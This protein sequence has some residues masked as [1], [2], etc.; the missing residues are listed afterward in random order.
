MK[1]FEDNSAIVKP[2]KGLCELIT[3]QFEDKILRILMAA[4][5]V[6]LVIGIL[7]E[8]IETGWIEGFA[9]FVA[10]F[11]IV[12]VSV[13]TMIRMMTRNWFV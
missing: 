12:S 5:L 1:Q 13:F 10:I 3:E 9:I 7:T 2:P 11:I 4:S 6:S 8:P